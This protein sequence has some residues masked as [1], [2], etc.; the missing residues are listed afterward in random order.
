MRSVTIAGAILLSGTLAGFEPS[1]ERSANTLSRDWKR[2]TAAGLDVVGNAREGDLKG[3]ARHIASFRATL[4]ILIPGLQLSA[5]QPTTLI[6]FRDH[7]SFT[8]F[9]PRD[10]RGRRQL[11]VAGY[12]SDAADRNYLVLPVFVDRRLTYETAFHEYTHYVISRNFRGVPLWLNE[13]LAE[14]YSTFDLDD[15][16]RAI[17]GR[18]PSSRVWTLSTE[19]LR[20]L[21]ALLLGESGS[22]G[23]GSTDVDLFY[24]QSW[25]F[26]HFMT[27][28]EGGKRQGQIVKYLELL[29]ETKS[30]EAAARE[31]F[32]TTLEALDREMARYIED[33]RLR[34]LRVTGIKW[35]APDVQMTPLSEADVAETKARLLIELNVPSEAKRYVARALELDPLHLSARITHARL[36]SS[37]NRPA[38][39]V[40]ELEKIARDDE[41][42]FSAQFYLGRALYDEARYA[43][44]IGAFNRSLRIARQAAA[45]W[46]QLSLAAMALGQYEQSDSAMAQLQQVH[47]EPRWHYLRALEAFKLGR[48]D[49]VLP[50]VKVFIERAGSAD[51]SAP[52]AAF[53][54]V[55]AAHRTDRADE[56]TSLLTRIVPALPLKS[57]TLT[58]A[59]FMQGEL[60]PTD[61]LDKAGDTGQR[62]EAHTY[63]AMR[64]IQGGQI[65]EARRH[66]EWVRDK[67]DRDYTE[68]EL[69]VA[70]LKRLKP[71]KVVE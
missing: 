13:G 11:N 37:E 39:A 20:P 31:A 34:G 23:F 44:A 64:L 42:N 61:F 69:A 27:L 2:F 28:S 60:S 67:G 5:P 22:R 26:V 63:I 70:E 38:D 40:V 19:R 24:A 59:R 47:S 52:Y 71:R 50:D 33:F 68:Y 57:W 48:Y 21:R 66:L 58:I 35:D 15:E 54:G 32:G 4:E 46:L 55:I 10:A 49:A 29:T 41:Q 8:E 53:L 62:T 7:P 56:G 3:A 36:A 16:G 25:L 6:V 30:A 12:F 18:V 9:A 1:Q 43:E 65:D 51:E 14:F 17:V 45:P